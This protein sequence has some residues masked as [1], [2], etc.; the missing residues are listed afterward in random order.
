MTTKEKSSTACS[1]YSRVHKF[2]QNFGE[3]PYRRPL[4][5]CRH[6]YKDNETIKMNFKQNG[7]VWSGFL[8]FRIQTTEEHM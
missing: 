7:R 8:W 4:A 2:I 3:K 5:R 6:K 1:K